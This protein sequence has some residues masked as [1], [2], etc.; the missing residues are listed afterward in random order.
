M[1]N[2]REFHSVSA[3]PVIVTVPG[4]YQLTETHHEAPTPVTIRV[5][6]TAS[7]RVNVNCPHARLV[8][9]EAKEV[10]S[11]RRST[12]SLPKSAKAW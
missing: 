4:G 6:H 7:V 10:I 11:S 2:S 1:Q 9:V 3:C 12:V 5:G 8:L